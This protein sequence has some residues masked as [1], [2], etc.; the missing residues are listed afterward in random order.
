M[1]LNVILDVVSV[2]FGAIMLVLA[3][4]IFMMSFVCNP[5]MKK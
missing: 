2:P 4:I 1:V 3:F 5:C